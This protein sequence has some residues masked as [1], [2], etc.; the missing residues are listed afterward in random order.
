MTEYKADCSTILFVKENDY[1]TEKEQIL[2]WENWKKQRWGNCKTLLSIPNG[3]RAR[4]QRMKS[5]DW[6]SYQMKRVHSSGYLEILKW[7]WGWDEKLLES[8]V[9]LIFKYG[10]NHSLGQL[11]AEVV[12]RFYFLNNHSTI[13]SPTWPSRVLSLLIRHVKYWA[14]WTWA[15]LHDWWPQEREC[16]RT[17]TAW[18]PNHTLSGCEEAQIEPEAES[19]GCKAQAGRKGRCPLTTRINPSHVSKWIFRLIQPQPLCFLA[20]A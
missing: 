16:S 4:G 17:D 19:S 12:R 15:E 14:P 13:S 3:L 7:K 18:L 11:S 6:K 1:Q 10:Y 9:T 8:N 20:E 2:I 5:H